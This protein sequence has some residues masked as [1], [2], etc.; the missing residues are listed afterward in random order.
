MENEDNN[1]NGSD[2]NDNP[3]VN[4]SKNK[5]LAATVD[6]GRDSHSKDR[7]D[8]V[9]GGKIEEEGEEAS[10]LLDKA[11]KIDHGGLDGDEI[12]G[13]TIKINDARF[14]MEDPEA[15]ADVGGGCSQEESMKMN[16][17]NIERSY[18]AKQ[19]DDDERENDSDGGGG[20]QRSVKEEVGLGI[21]KVRS[22]PK[23]KDKEGPSDSESIPSGLPSLDS[24]P[25]ETCCPYVFL[26][27]SIF[28]CFQDWL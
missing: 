15:S 20:R 25:E 23:E 6:A 28:G 16:K 19:L 3:A 10:T 24:E 18:R 26:D 4:S 14:Q 8:G 5:E 13:I 21:D 12:F 1:D 27:V 17:R 11:S 22:K 9:M 2:R 7:D